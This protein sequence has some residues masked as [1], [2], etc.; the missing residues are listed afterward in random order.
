M[1][2]YYFSARIDDETTLCIAPMSDRKI[3]LSGEEI[4]D[5]S[6]YFLYFA[7]GAGAPVEVE[8][9][10][11]MRSDEAAFRLKELLRLD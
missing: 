3:E 5:T 8:V 10:A 1:S 4:S 6:G 9:V 2:A 11:Q 7:K